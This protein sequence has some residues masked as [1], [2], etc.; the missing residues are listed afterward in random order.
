M[1]AVSC[2][3]FIGG[4]SDKDEGR[5]GEG[6]GIPRPSGELELRW[7]ILGSTDAA[8]CEAVGAIDFETV[9]SDIYAFLEFEADCAE[10]T[11]PLSLPIGDYVTRSRLVDAD[12]N[13][14]THRVVLDRVR[15]LEDE[16]TVLPIDFP[17]EYIVQPGEDEADAAVPPVDEPDAETPPPPEEVVDAGGDAAAPPSDDASAP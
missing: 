8:A 17:S 11:A 16:V 7:S 5:Y 2:L 3:F 12:D 13:T 10:F 15:I 14:I 4:C 1:A 9:V 6:P